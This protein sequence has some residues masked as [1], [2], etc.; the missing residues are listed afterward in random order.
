[1]FLAQGLKAG[2]WKNVLVLQVRYRKERRAVRG[3]VGFT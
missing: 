2:K 1:M 3:R